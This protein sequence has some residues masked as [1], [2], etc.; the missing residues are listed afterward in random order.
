MYT[1]IYFFFF[2]EDIKMYLYLDPFRLLF[3]FAIQAIFMRVFLA[4][5]ERILLMLFFLWVVPSSV[6]R[7][8]FVDTTEICRL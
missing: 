4:C 1:Y 2:K 5:D 6:F 8:G 7:L 3:L